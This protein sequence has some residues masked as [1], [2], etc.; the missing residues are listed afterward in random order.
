MYK[1]D[2]CYVLVYMCTCMECV[3]VCA[4]EV[5]RGCMCRVLYICVCVCTWVCMKNVREVVCAEC[6]VLVCIH[7]ECAK[8]VMCWC[9]TE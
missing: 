3:C 9:I 6:F 2:E 4:W 5:C 8:S 7:G 1:S